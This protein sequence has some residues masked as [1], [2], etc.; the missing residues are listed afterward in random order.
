MQAMDLA[1]RETL[2]DYS[3]QESPQRHL[4]D[5]TRGAQYKW[6][7]SM[8]DQNLREETERIARLYISHFV[9]SH[10]QYYFLR[11]TIQLARLSGARVLLFWPRMN[12]YLLRAMNATPAIAG[13]RE[14]VT[15]IARMEGAQIVDMNDDRILNCN[16]FY[17]ASHLSV[18]C[19]PEMHRV[20]LSR[21]TDRPLA[22]AA[23]R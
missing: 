17:D 5:I 11:Q 20:I 1:S 19:F 4:L 18:S 9:V 16:D 12:P 13:I 22:V 10:E 15:E 14:R 7:G 3:L 2:N 6:T 21:L 23:T 8:S